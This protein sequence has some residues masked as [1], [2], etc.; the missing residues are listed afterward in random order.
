MMLPADI[1]EAALSRVVGDRRETAHE[2]PSLGLP[3]AVGEVKCRN[4]KGASF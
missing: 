2:A 1:I 3:H 4:A